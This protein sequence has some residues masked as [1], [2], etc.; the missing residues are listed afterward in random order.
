[1]VK[2]LIA[3]DE[4]NIIQLIRNLLDLELHGIEIIGEAI[5][6]RLA[7]DMVR[8]LKPDIL[9]TDIKMPCLNGLELIEKI[10]QLGSSVHIVV[11]SGH[12]EF[13][14][15]YSA[16]KHGVDDFL[17]KPIIKEDLNATVAKICAQI[18]GEQGGIKSAVDHET[19]LGVNTERMRAKLLLDVGS[20]MEAC[21]SIEE[22][23]KTY[24]VQFGPGFFVGI[25]IKLDLPGAEGDDLLIMQKCCKAALECFANA[26][27]DMEFGIDGSKVR[28]LVNL[29]LG[30]KEKLLR[31]MKQLYEAISLELD[32]YSSLPIS[33]GVGRFVESYRDI[34][35]TLR[36]A[37]TQVRFKCIQTSPHIF[38]ANEQT[39]SLVEIQLPGALRNNLRVLMEISDIQAIGPWLQSVFKE[40]ALQCAEKPGYVLG[41]VDATEKTFWALCDMLA[42]YV[43]AE[44]RKHWRHE[45]ESVRGFDNLIKT[46]ENMLTDVLNTDY[47]QRLQRESYPISCAKEYIA[48]HLSEQIKLEDIAQNVQLSPSYLSTLFKRET[49]ENISDYMQY[50]RIEEAKRLLKS[51][52]LYINEISERVGYTDAKH[53]SKLFKSQV[54]SRPQD[55]RKLYA[56]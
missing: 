9:I 38:Y 7:L 40:A 41:L 42:V 31:R 49:G 53:F 3:D 37:E 14:Y 30:N 47:Q 4:K 51:T 12:K 18:R 1:M 46:L 5:N 54:G 23:N 45:L 43:E 39:D 34:P 56:W 13:D 2:L 55:Y 16:L 6:G 20:G 52:N 25:C 19:Y 50:L 17:I 15:A 48:A 28:G 33:I 26:V 22:V 8:E 32:I 27:V 29:T 21:T 24:A 36:E 44:K 11:I 10:R 35:I